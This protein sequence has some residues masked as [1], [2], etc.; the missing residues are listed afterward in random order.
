M[1]RKLRV[2]KLQKRMV[3]RGLHQARKLLVLG[4][5][6]QGRLNGLDTLRKS[7]RALL[8]SLPKTEAQIKYRETMQ[9]ALSGDSE[10]LATLSGLRDILLAESRSQI[11]QQLIAIKPRRRQNGTDRPD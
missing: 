9:R 4:L 3:V 5:S 8:D 10:A 6:A 1:R 2:A 11:E 7:I